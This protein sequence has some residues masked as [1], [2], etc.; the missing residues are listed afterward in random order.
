MPIVVQTRITNRAGEA[1]R[2]KSY[3]RLVIMLRYDARQ[4]KR[5][6]R[7]PQRKRI[8]PTER[9]EIVSALPIGWPAAADQVLE[10]I[11]HDSRRDRRRRDA[12]Q[13]RGFRPR[14]LEDLAGEIKR[15]DD[16]DRVF[17]TQR[18]D[19]VE[20]L[21]HCIGTGVPDSALDLFFKDRHRSHP[22][23]TSTQRPPT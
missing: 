11:L 23:R 10:R 12:V 20:D 5:L 17:V 3:P 19:I 15:A 6:R 16:A 22:G 4:R 8:A 7:M 2:G 18:L 1:E 14:I 9:L 21:R 13:R